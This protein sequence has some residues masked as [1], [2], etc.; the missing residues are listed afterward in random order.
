[1]WDGTININ[2]FTLVT[3][4]LKLHSDG[5]SVDVEQRPEG[6]RC[7]DAAEEDPLVLAVHAVHDV[8]GARHTEVKVALRVGVP[9]RESLSEH[10]IHF[11][12]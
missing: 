9:L 8:A 5:V 6:R 11:T 7:D 12:R 2:I 4:L 1:M 10:N 3:S